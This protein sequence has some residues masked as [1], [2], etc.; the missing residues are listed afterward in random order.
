MQSQHHA[1]TAHIARLPANPQ[2]TRTFY[3]ISKKGASQ[4]LANELLRVS[5]QVLAHK[6][7]PYI[8]KQW[9]QLKSTLGVFK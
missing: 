7:V 9:P 5:R 8:E 3:L 4:R 6:T 2:G 1:C